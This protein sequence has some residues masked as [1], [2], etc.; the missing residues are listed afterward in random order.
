MHMNLHYNKIQLDRLWSQQSLN[1]SEVE[2][3]GDNREGEEKLR[4]KGGVVVSL[5]RFTR[6]CPARVKEEGDVN[7]PVKLGSC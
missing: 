5:A 2:E 1:V 6:I 3:W 7:S 4:T